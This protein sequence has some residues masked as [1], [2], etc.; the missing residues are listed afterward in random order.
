M[1]GRKQKQ[2]PAR[3]G[4]WIGGEEVG[5][6]ICR[7]TVTQ[8]P[9]RIQFCWRLLEQPHTGAECHVHL[10]IFF[11]FDGLPKW[12]LPMVMWLLTLSQTSDSSWKKTTRQCR[13]SKQKHLLDNIIMIIIIVFFLFINRKS[14][15]AVVLNQQSLNLIW[16]AVWW[17]N[18]K[19]TQKQLFI[20]SCN[21]QGIGVCV[22][23][24]A[25][26]CFL[27]YV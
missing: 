21:G 22:C 6:Q 15:Q 24:C 27:V 9:W 2:P 17:T 7:P 25:L 19:T 8:K 18:H 14:V 10:N 1:N 11:F 12:K 23:V 5:W 20:D 4:G 16:A 3:R 26:A 13:N